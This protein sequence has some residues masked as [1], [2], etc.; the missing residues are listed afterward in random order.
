M[1]T[2][3]DFLKDDAAPNSMMTKY[4]VL[5]P[6]DHTGGNQF[7]PADTRA[8]AEA[9]AGVVGGPFGLKVDDPFHPPKIIP[10]TFDGS[11]P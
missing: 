5:V 2:A 11:K 1:S 7:I 4:L 8:Q 10:Y 6:T 9:I 3:S